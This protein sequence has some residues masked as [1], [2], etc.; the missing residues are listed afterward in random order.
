MQ[1]MEC[2]TCQKQ[3]RGGTVCPECDG[4]LSPV[5]DRST[6]AVVSSRADCEAEQTAFVVQCQHCRSITAA[7]DAERSD[8][9]MIGEAVRRATKDGSHIGFMSS[10]VTVRIGGC[11]CS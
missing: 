5:V 11:D 6:D 2:P 10:P 4:S 1:M 8:P 7:F 3:W 9:Q